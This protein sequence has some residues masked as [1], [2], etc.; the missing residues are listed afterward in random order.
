MQTK[1]RKGISFT[2]V[3]LLLPSSAESRQV[4]I[5]TS[6]VPPGF[7]ALNYARRSQIDI[8]YGGR[9]LCS[10]MA[11]FTAETVELSSPEDVVSRIPQ[12]SEPQTVAG[13][14]SGKVIAHSEL[15]CAPG[16]KEDCGRLYPDVAG[17]IFDDN[18]FRM[19]V[20]INKHYLTLQ[21]AD[22]QR[23]LPPSDGRLALLQNLSLAASGT[24]GSAYN[25]PEVPLGESVSADYTLS[26]ISLLSWREN[27]VYGSWDYSKNNQLNVDVLYG[28]RE[29]EG[30]SWQGGM[31]S[32]RGFGLNFSYDQRMLGARVATSYLTRTDTEL[33]RGTPI[34]VF[35]PTRGRVELR[36]DGKLLTSEFLEAGNQQLNTS[37]LP[38]GA[39][40]L[41]IRVVD[42]FGHELSRETRFFA[43]QNR[44]PA[45]GTWEWFVEGGKVLDRSSDQAFPKITDKFLGRAGVGRRLADAWSGTLAIAADNHDALLEAGLFNVGRFWD[46]SPHLMVGRHGDYGAGVDLQARVESISFFGHYRRLWNH[47]YVVDPKKVKADPKK[48]SVQDE[49]FHPQGNE[50][51]GPGF[52]QFTSSINAPLFTGTL[53]YRYSFNRTHLNSVDTQSLSWRSPLWRFEHYDLDCEFSAGQSDGKDVVLATFSF[54]LRDDRWSHRLTPAVEYNKTPEGEEYDERLQ[55]TSRWTDGD[56]LEGDMSFD[57]GVQVSAQQNRIDGRLKYGDH[58]GAM[59][60]ALV[61][62]RTHQEQATGYSLNMST[63]LMTNGDY[64]TVGGENMS[65]SGVVIYISGRDGDYFDVLIDD[66]RVTYAVVGEPTLVTL[67]PYHQYRIGLRPSGSAFYQF[68]EKQQL[69]TLYPGNVVKMEL[70][71]QPLKLAFGR[72]LFNKHPIQALIK[73]G[74]AQASTDEG[75]MF[76]IEVDAET[77]AIIIEIDNQW[78]CSLRL[79]LESDSDILRLGTV[80]Y[81]AES[82]NPIKPAGE[83]L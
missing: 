62:S 44:L 7:E 57:G 52:E 73:N 15:V 32:S 20:F 67:N 68:E 50:L 41:Q 43:K 39:Y 42:D 47:D 17:V 31:L 51:L 11:T 78:S 72:I 69:V 3:S 46:I 38:E 81:T 12:L 83:A 82:C 80:N 71:A 77:Q 6:E 22:I 45:A 58:R 5:A 75:G 23:F 4:F 65:Q 30:L 66:R 59:D 16:E 70:N 33:I 14:L 28:Q 37:N 35:L 34:N 48:K 79:P 76:Q 25:D 63:S 36:R 9:Y 1:V 27:S 21:P 10:Q 2:L 56:W 49:I 24:T 61:H 18:R 64:V 60:L 13:L 40:N 53:S 55:L 8:Y 54:N 74:M 26:G 29:F 19:D